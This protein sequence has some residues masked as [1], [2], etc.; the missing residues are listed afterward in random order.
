MGIKSLEVVLYYSLE[1]AITGMG[2]VNLMCLIL[3]SNGQYYFMNIIL[4]VLAPNVVNIVMK[5]NLF[6]SLYLLLGLS[7]YELKFVS[8]LL[9]KS[10]NFVLF[11]ERETFQPRSWYLSMYLFVLPVAKFILVLLKLVVH[12]SNSW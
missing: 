6:I 3:L 7:S 5:A 10:I 11:F 12:V 9:M 8:V 2:L 4:M 1:K